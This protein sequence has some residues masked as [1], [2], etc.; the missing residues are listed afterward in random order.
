MQPLWKWNGKFYGF[1][2]GDEL[3]TTEKQHVGRF[4]GND[5]F[6]KDGQYIGELIGDR[7][8]T[9]K[10]KKIFRGQSFTP[11]TD[12]IVGIVKHVDYVSNVMSSG[13]EDFP[14]PENL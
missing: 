4:Q 10:S 1:R 6:G 13:C 7:L 8:I 12:K 9:N 2:D 14:D 11:R 5:I 3:F